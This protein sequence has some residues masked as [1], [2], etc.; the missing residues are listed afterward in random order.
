MKR[1]YSTLSLMLRRA[2][3]TVAKAKTELAALRHDLAE[4]LGADE[5]EDLAL[6]QSIA[7]QQGKIQAL[8]EAAKTLRAEAEASAPTEQPVP[9]SEA[10]TSAPFADA[11]R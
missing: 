2:E 10:A 1:P 3:G 6:A 11:N 9:E 8:E 7:Q 4:Y 5:S